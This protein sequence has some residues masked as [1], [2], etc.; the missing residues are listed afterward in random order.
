MSKMPS[1]KEMDWSG[2]TV[3]VRTDYNVPLSP[4]G[5][6]WI[7]R[8]P[9]RIIT[10]F[11]TINFLRERGNKVILMSHLGRPKS[12]EDG[13]CSLL[14]VAGY[15]Q[16]NTDWPVE[17]IDELDDWDSVRATIA[18]GEPGSVFLLE[19]LRFHPG[20]KQNDPQL[21]KNLASLADFFVNE[22]F[23]S[24]HREHASVVGVAKLLPSAAGVAL[25]S[26]VR[27]F[28]QLLDNP[29][30]PFVVVV[31]GAKISDK[32]DPIVNL[33]RRADAV[34]IGGGVA[35][36]FLK[37]VGL[38]VQKSYL[39]DAPADWRKEGRDFVDVANEILQE[40]R[41]YRLLKDGYIPLPKIIYPVD[42]VAAAAIDSRK[43]SIV[44]L[45]SNEKI[46]DR[47]NQMY[48]DIGPKTIKL[49]R[50]LIMQAETVFWNGP[51]G[52]FEKAPFVHGTK[53]IA[54]AVAKT[55]GVTLVGGGDTIAALDRFGYFNSVD[56]VSMAGSAALEFL[57][58]KR[59]PGLAALERE[60]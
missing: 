50:E 32:I 55:G 42:V 56:Y 48:L 17:F 36:N 5:H 53:E 43:T 19:N 30:H 26:E 11:E 6:K 27:A 18:A 28:S 22:A 45:T 16:K 51:M 1:V 13:Q 59:L 25:D 34:L 24:C 31:G 15:L 20:E 49:Y 29:V 2:K 4:R 44:E 7:V 39:Q 37:A 9:R 58:G 33:A 40:N 21:A 52:A 3:L 23:S 47:C 41:S 46:C 54:R 38:A 10:S 12:R 8:D 57:S 14:P 60:Q 35:N